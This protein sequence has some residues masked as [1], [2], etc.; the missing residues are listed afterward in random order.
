MT[1]P[2]AILTRAFFVP[3]KAEEA[4]EKLVVGQGGKMENEEE[5]ML[6]GTEDIMFQ[7]GL[8]PSL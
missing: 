3:G 2:P 4:F 1:P 8:L 5:G 7:T 6:L